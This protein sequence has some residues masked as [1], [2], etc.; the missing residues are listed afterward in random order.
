M[1]GIDK[2][3]EIVKKMIKYCDKIIG[4]RNENALTKEKYLANE[5]IQLA[6]DMCIF[7]LTELSKHADEE[8]KLKHLEIEWAQLSGMRNVHAHDYDK[9][10]REIIWDTIQNDIDSLKD[11]L[12]KIN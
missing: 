11:R 4:I 2:N 12:E 5:V 1:Q 10:D 6:L 7:Q 8:F 9:I 3:K